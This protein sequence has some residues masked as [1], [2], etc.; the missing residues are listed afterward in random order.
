MPDT[1]TVT[2]EIPII[3]DYDVVI[4][5]GGPSGFIAAIAA[6]RGGART[7]LIERYGFLGGMATAGLVAPI[8]EFNFHGRRVIGGIPREFVEG[9][10]KIGGAIE[11]NPKGNISFDPEKYKIAAQRMVLESGVSLYLHSYLSGCIKSGE[12]T[13]HVLIE[14]KNGAE[15]IGGKYLID[16]T[17]DADLAYRA[18]VPMQPVNGPLQPASLCFMLGGVDTKALPLAHHRLEGVNS[19]DAEIRRLLSEMSARTEIPVFGGP[20][21][22]SVV[23]EGLLLVNMTRAKADMTDNRQATR[24]E[25]LL[26]ENVHRFVELFREN[27]PAFRDAFLVSTAAQVGVR[28]TRRIKGAHILSGEEYLGAINFSDSVARGC[29]SVD[30]HDSTTNGQRIER[31]N[32]A[33]FVPYRSL[34][35]P[36]FSNLL[37]AGRAFSA[38]EVASASVRVQASCMGLGQA[39]GAAA[40]LCFSGGA[41]VSDVDIRKL[42]EI[43]IGYGAVL[44]D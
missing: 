27:I 19:H 41:K 8:S 43:L 7:A 24:I 35:A 34:F 40:A 14:N 13:T 37:V 5:G 29:H 9:L 32:N 39:A 26:R 22:C 10:Q 31:L 44:E 12:S 4:C 42:R 36:G 15:A 25:C 21:Y 18:G 20:W 11:E 3:A 1:I 33:G 23:S 2:K 16:C 17:G 38:D 28:E 30:I 6:A